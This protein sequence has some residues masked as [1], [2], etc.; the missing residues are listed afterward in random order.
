[1]SEGGDG[2]GGTS[3]AEIF[4]VEQSIVTKEEVGEG[5]EGE[6]KDARV[7]VG[8]GSEQQ[9]HH[10]SVYPPPHAII[11]TEMPSM[12][13]LLGSA[14]WLSSNLATSRRPSP[15]ASQSGDTPVGERDDNDS[16]RHEEIGDEG[17]RMQVRVWERQNENQ[18]H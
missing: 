7:G 15:D 12:R 17:V 8:P 3:G 13:L 9:L 4:S 10:C 14:L 2:R 5:G 1:M 16:S 6:G 11:S 18:Y